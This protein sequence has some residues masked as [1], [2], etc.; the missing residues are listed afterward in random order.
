MFP[1]QRKRFPDSFSVASKKEKNQPE[2]VWQY[3]NHFHLFFP[4]ER[5]F[6]G[7][8]SVI[9]FRESRNKTCQ[10]FC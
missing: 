8:Y 4:R 9:P 5:I 1:F 10:A 6:N 3:I 2:A 7:F